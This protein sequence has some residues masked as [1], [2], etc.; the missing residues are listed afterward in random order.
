[1]A[2]T[3][4]GTLRLTVD[5]DLRV[6]ADLDPVP[7]DVIIARS[8][9]TRQEL[10]EMSIGFRV[11]K[12]RDEWNDDYTERVI[13]EVALDEV[14]IVRRGANPYTTATDRTLDEI[15]E[16]FTDYTEDELRRAYVRLEQLLTVPTTEPDSQER[17]IALLQM[18]D[19]R[20][21]A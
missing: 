3:R 12:S 11:P 9:I 1:M 7:S 20:R 8:A 14:S 2:S 15:I 5:P 4:G 16:A 17:L 19:H 10:G 13:H 6:T 18:W 21:T